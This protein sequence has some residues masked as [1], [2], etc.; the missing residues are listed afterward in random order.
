MRVLRRNVTR[1]AI[2]IGVA[3]L[4]VFSRKLAAPILGNENPYHTVWLA[5]M[6][7]AFYC[8]MGPAIVA[9][10]LS[11]AGVWYWLLP[12]YHR[13]TGHSSTEVFG[14]LVFLVLSA[15]I[16]AL[17]EY[18]RKTVMAREQAEQAFQKTQD[19]LVERVKQRT[20][21]LQEKTV[22]LV[23]EQNATRSLSGRI[24]VLQDEER[25][26]MARGLH[27]SLGQYLAALKMNLDQF[28]SEQA[29]QAAIA[30]E[31]SA[32]VEKCLAETRTISHLLHP[33]LLDECGFDSAARL[34]IEGFSRRSGIVVEFDA[35]PDAIRL[36]PELELAL[37]RTVQEALTNVHKHAGA[38]AAIISLKMDDKDVRLEISDNGRGIPQER[39][40]DLL[41]G[42]TE[43]GVGLA[44]MR[45]RVRQ[46]N[47]TFEIRS[48]GTGT[49]V[50]VTTPRVE[51]VPVAQ[52]PAAVPAA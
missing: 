45:E 6:F 34:Y 52:D 47:G 20:A 15:V 24:L 8:G 49:V 2:A 36:H 31:S 9:V 33:P 30:S 43:V 17:G 40:S 32:I 3:A 46:L 50:A 41:Y 19:Q 48:N 1:Y 18:T 10:L 5:A 38:T 12:P 23:Q 28:A 11:A 51:Q 7:C 35:P 39:L 22:A 13:F 4:A 44:G 29:R 37:F 25:R 21:A 14:M 16:V 42:A 26:R 27:D